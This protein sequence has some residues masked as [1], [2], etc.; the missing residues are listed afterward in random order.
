MAV[1]KFHD[2]QIQA[3]LQRNVA[4]VGAANDQEQMLVLLLV[5]PNDRISR[6]QRQ[7]LD[8]H[9]LTKS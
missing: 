9:L 5:R 1:I 7:H 2:T 4:E 6:T 3:C 8:T